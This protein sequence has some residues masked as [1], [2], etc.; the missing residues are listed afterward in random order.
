MSALH[1]MCS[2]NHGNQGVIPL[3]MPLLRDYFVLTDASPYVRVGTIGTTR[4]LAK[5][6]YKL[7]ARQTPS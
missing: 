7:R 4:H 5:K 3:N 6:C 1:H 2:H